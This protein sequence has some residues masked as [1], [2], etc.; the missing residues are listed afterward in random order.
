MSVTVAAVYEN[1]V[2]R[3]QE[4]LD[5]AE[6]THVEVTINRAA[7]DM[8]WSEEGETRRRDL[9]DK[10]IAGTICAEEAAELARLD[11]LSNEYFDR[12]APPPIDGAL[13][14]HDRLVKQR[15]KGH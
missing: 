10:D 12:I 7:G 4:P 3:P 11:R 13:R 5:L 8:A 2:L 6:G 1:G 15:D 9:I 14:L